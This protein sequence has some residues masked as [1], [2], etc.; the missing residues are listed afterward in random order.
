[1]SEQEFADLFARARQGDQGALAALQAALE[2]KLRKAAH[3][4]L[5]RVLR[6]YVGSMDIVQSA[7]RTLLRGLRAGK[8]DVPGPEKLTALAL[9]IL[10]RKVAQKWRKVRK[11]LRLSDRLAQGANSRSAAPDGA[12]R[13]VENAELVHHLMKYMNETEKELVRLCLQGHTITSAA[14]HLKL[15]PAYAR[16][17]LGR[18]RARLAAMFDLPLG[19]P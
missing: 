15:T 17:L 8:Y 13:A 5:G 9:R 11:D 18:M 12:A 4:R 14:E 2:E 10:Q 6:R 16:V 3:R 1:M 19:F 7:Q